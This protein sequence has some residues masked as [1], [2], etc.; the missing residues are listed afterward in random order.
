MMENRF[1]RCNK[2]IHTKGKLPKVLRQTLVTVTAVLVLLSTM[3]TH[4][5]EVAQPTK[6]TDASTKFEEKVLDNKSVFKTKNFDKGGAIISDENYRDYNDVLKSSKLLEGKKVTANRVAKAKTSW[7]SLPGTTY[8]YE[9]LDTYYCVPATMQTILRYNNNSLP[10]TQDTIANDMG[11]TSGVGVD[12]LKVSDYLNE[13]QTKNT[14]AI[15]SKYNKSQMTSRIKTDIS[16][17]QVPTSIRISVSNSSDWFY[18]TY[19]HALVC[20]SITTDSGT[21]QLVDPGVGYSWY[22]KSTDDL[23]KVFTHMAW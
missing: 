9:Q 21:V 12:F 10:P 17:L 6:V 3:V 19:G 4:A 22:N 15:H 7:Y 5:A 11:F 13:H 2:N 8:R 14:Y 20:N 23:Y 16:S 18:T 1:N